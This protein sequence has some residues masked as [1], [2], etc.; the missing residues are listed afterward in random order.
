MALFARAL[1]DAGSFPAPTLAFGAALSLF[2]GRY[3]LEAGISYLPTRT[4]PLPNLGSATGDIDLLL[5]HVGACAAFFQR[6]PFELGPCA[7]FEAGRIQ[8]SSAGVASP[9]E[10]A[11]P[12]LALSAGGR[13]G[14]TFARPVSLVVGLGAAVPI[15]HPDLIV[16]GLGT[17]HRASPVVGR[18]ELGVEVRF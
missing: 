3:R 10:G 1:A 13:F 17:V 6:P 16:S 12:W 9:G 2:V 15:V 18:A 5:A 14:W 7:S 8:S 4:F 11:A